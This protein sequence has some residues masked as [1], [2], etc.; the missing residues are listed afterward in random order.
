[1]G[2]VAF[3]YLAEIDVGIARGGADIGVAF[4]PERAPCDPSS[5]WLPKRVVF[6]W[7][8]LLEQPIALLEQLDVRKFHLITSQWLSKNRLCVDL[9]NLRAR[10]KFS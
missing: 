10:Y 9:S 5:R 8:L 7:E 4:G 6:E 3:R 1:M 2:A